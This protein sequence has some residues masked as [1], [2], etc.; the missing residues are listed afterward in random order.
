VEAQNTSNADTGE[1]GNESGVAAMETEAEGAEEA[2]A[3]DNKGKEEE[4]EEAEDD[5]EED[6]AALLASGAEL[7]V[8]VQFY[9]KSHIHD[10]WIPL[11]QALDP[12]LYH[13]T[14]RVEA[15]AKQLEDL[16]AWFSSPASDK[17]AREDYK[18]Q[19]QL[20]R[21]MWTA[22]ETVVRTL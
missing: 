19:R 15:F 18:Y 10:A 5:E 6:D 11:K 17:Q 13:G 16:T 3:D 14:P 20:D 12:S 4:A 7:E 1:D 22:W 9:G 21:Q 8:L 2:K